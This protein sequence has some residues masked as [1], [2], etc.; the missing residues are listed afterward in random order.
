MVSG[1]LVEH[2]DRGDS[3]EPDEELVVDDFVDSGG[4]RL[5]RLLLL[6]VTSRDCVDH[7]SHDDRDIEDEELLV[8]VGVGRGEE[9]VVVDFH[10]S[11]SPI[12]LFCPLPE[13]IFIL[14]WIDPL[15]HQDGLAIGSHRPDPRG[16]SSSRAAAAG[17]WTV[18]RSRSGHVRR[19]CHA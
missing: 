12:I 17:T 19:R 4:E 10:L 13:D 6:E 14:Q 8:G 3:Q 15:E 11:V 5:A 16:E 2:P 9:V 1:D 7:R 18:P